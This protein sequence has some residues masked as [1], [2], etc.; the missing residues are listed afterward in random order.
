MPAYI[1]APLL[2][3][4]CGTYQTDSSLMHVI[5][6]IYIYKT[7]FIPKIVFDQ[8]SKTESPKF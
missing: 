5:I 1:F 3:L 8:K 7:D 2:C 6:Y 4:F